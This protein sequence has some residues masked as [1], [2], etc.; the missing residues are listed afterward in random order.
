[1][2][3]RTVQRAYLLK[4]CPRCHGDLVLEADEAVDEQEPGHFEYACLQCG[5]RFGTVAEV[6]QQPAP[7]GIRAA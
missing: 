3:T 4:G 1:M 5:R 7:A 2:Q 6:A